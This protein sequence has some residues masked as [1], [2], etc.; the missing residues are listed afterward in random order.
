MA[1]AGARWHD[2]A[3]VEH[4]CPR[5]SPPDPRVLS[6]SIRIA[7]VLRVALRGRVGDRIVEGQNVVGLTFV[8]VSVGLVL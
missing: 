4:L 5:R 2:V 3:P 1:D 7:S 8:G 6:V